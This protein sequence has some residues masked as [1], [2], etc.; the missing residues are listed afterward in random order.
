M[1]LHEFPGNL[2]LPFDQRYLVLK[3]NLEAEKPAAGINQE[4]EALLTCA[5]FALILGTAL[6][7]ARPANS[8]LT[9]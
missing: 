4:L 2:A 9:R 5:S 8:P 1:L 6:I 7:P 3:M